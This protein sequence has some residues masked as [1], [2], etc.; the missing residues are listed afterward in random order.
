MEVVN[1]GK[2][3][4]GAVFDWFYKCPVF[5]EL[6]F[7][8]AP[9]DNGNA[10]LVPNDVISSLSDDNLTE[11]AYI[12]GSKIRIYTFTAIQFLP[13][14]TGSNMEA[15]ENIDYVRKVQ[16]IAAWIDEQAQQGIL[17]DFGE[18]CEIQK[19]EVLNM[20][21]GI[22]AVD[23]NGAKYMFAVRFKYLDKTLTF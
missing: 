1:I 11:Q 8:F 9:D 13:Y 20:A 2:D 14:G 18:K 6:F 10:V 16:E 4:H 5:Q 21:D 22:S 7:I 19:V 12:D 15:V 23:E 17:P 3:K